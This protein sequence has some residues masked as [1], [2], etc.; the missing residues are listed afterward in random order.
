MLDKVPTNDI[1]QTPTDVPTPNAE[2]IESSKLEW[3]PELGQ[4][5]WNDAQEKIT[6]L[7][8]KLAEGEKPWRLPT[9]DELETKFKKGGPSITGFQK[10]FY[11]SNSDDG[12]WAWAFLSDGG[13]G[14]SDEK[15]EIFS[16]RA[17]R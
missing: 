7:N 13:L 3:G 15:S 2:N 4:M 5:S 14:T 9:K 12:R 8:A 10:D 17:V 1:P 16:V 11:W 6:E